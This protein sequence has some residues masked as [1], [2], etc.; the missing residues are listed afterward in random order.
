M[1]YLVQLSY[2]SKKKIAADTL[3]RLEIC[4]KEYK[5]SKESM[6]TTENIGNETC[7]IND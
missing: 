1:K 7:V 4:E 2:I 3:S 6:N 5:E